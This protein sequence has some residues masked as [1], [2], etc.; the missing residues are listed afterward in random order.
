MKRILVI[1]D[2]CVMGKN[3]CNVSISILSAM[4][5]EVVTVPVFIHFSKWTD[6]VKE[7]SEDYF[8]CQTDLS[9]KI[10][11][12]TDYFIENKIHFDCI[13]I[14]GKFSKIQI[15]KIRDLVTNCL[16][17]DCLLLL[18][19]DTDFLSLKPICEKSN[20][21]ISNLEKIYNLTDS[22]SSEDISNKDY[23]ENIL[24]EKKDIFSGSLIVTDF[25]INSEK[26]AI[27]LFEKN[28][29]DI[30]WFYVNNYNSEFYGLDDIFSAIVAGAI[31]K[32]INIE[33]AIRIGINFID[34]AVKST[35]SKP[36]YNWYGADFESILS[37][38]ILQ[39]SDNLP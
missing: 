34:K 35:L 23:L 6:S 31:T 30:K 11:G 9:A 36:D 19:V 1:Q 4:E 39:L 12:Y 10:K 15:E 22:N 3:S 29:C 20:V 32:K 17:N 37:E 24:I 2:I 8:S 16:S 14:N 27:A 38:L 5:I 25:I 26:K 28:K 18:K 21:I 33:K 13:F 7:N